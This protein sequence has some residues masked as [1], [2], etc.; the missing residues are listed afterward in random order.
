[1]ADAVLLIHAGFVLF[2]VLG[3]ALII[4]GG[5]RRWRWVRNPW[6]R[7]VHLAAIAIVVG[8]SW[9]GFACP[10]TT[11][12]MALRAQ[13]GGPVYD[14]SFIAHWVRTLLYYQAPPWVFTVAYS[15]FAACVI[16]SWIAVR[17]Q[18]FSPQACPQP[19]TPR[20]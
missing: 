7:I 9:L 12:E 19:P 20:A 11:I 17:P 1:M 14:E 3:L 15:A 6:F 2:V 5:A 8:E 18:S 4:A 13:S 16:A 10:L